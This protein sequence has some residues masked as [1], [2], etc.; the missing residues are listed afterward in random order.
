MI[1]AKGQF[2]LDESVWGVL[3][4]VWPKPGMYF[5]LGFL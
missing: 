3:N 5:S 2:E 1:N 4:V